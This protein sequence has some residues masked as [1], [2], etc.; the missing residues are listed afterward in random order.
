MPATRLDYSG[1][2]HYNSATPGWA[3]QPVY[4]RTG[5]THL[6]PIDLGGETT[7]ETDASKFGRQAYQAGQKFQNTQA[8]QGVLNSQNEALSAIGQRAFGGPEKGYGQAQ[9]AAMTSP[10]HQQS[11]DN[12]GAQGL[13]MGQAMSTEGQAQMRGSGQAQQ[14]TQQADQNRLQAVGQYGQAAG[15]VRQQLDQLSQFNATQQGEL[16]RNIYNTEYGVTKAAQDRNDAI[17][18]NSTQ[19]AVQTAMSVIGL[20]AMLA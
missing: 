19:G 15:G 18:A 9:E 10:Y 5:G 11:L 12:G 13:S 8:D 14:L 6:G 4:E 3:D 20:I 2:D 1:G 16:T 7:G 17:N